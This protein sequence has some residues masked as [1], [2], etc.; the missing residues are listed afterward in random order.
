[1][2]VL[3]VAAV[4]MAL[5]GPSFRRP[6][7]VGWIL[8]ASILC[9][10]E[11]LAIQRQN[12][13]SEERQTFMER[14][15]TLEFKIMSKELDGTIRGMR[16]LTRLSA[17]SLNGID[18]GISVMTGGD[19]F[20]VYQ[21]QINSPRPTAGVSF[22][23]SVK[24]KNPLRT[25]NVILSK[26]WC[27]TPND[28]GQFDLS[29]NDVYVRSFES[30]TPPTVPDFSRIL[31]GPF[32]IL[33]G[34]AVYFGTSSALNGFWNHLIKIRYDNKVWS[35]RSFVYDYRKG[36]IHIVNEVHSPSFPTAELKREPLPL[37]KD[38]CG[39]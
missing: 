29:G 34:R 20:P 25:L 13:A 32:P 7:Q 3:S 21:V 9:V 35:W 27:A 26:A 33:N 8:I 22:I 31:S 10:F 38:D 4:I 28:T 19:S 6:E 11:F 37:T 14:K 17:R 16:N 5:R 39:Q 36:R 18:K 1:M 24:G 15:A 23:L 2:S 12:T 30:Y